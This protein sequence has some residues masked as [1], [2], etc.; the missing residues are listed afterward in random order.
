MPE[1][2]PRMPVEKQKSD[3]EADQIEVSEE[4][5]EQLRDFACWLE[6]QQNDP[7][8]DYIHLESMNI[9]S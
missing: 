4:Q 6:N 5:T 8:S 2:E 3:V 9:M 7:H 1:I